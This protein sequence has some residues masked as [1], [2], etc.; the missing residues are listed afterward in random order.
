M[1]ELELKEEYVKKHGWEKIA[2]YKIN[3]ELLETDCDSI[4][5]DSDEFN[6]ITSP[7]I[8]WRDKDGE[9]E[10]I[11]D[12]IDE[13]IADIEDSNMDTENFETFEQFKEKKK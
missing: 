6:E 1:N 8:F 12:E 13:L 9:N 5:I 7:V 2:G 4:Y 10:Q 11:F 3:T